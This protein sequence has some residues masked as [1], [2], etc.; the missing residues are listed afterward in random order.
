VKPYQVDYAIRTNSDGRLLKQGTVDLRARN[1]SAAKAAARE[2]VWE[3]DQQCS[4]RSG[5][6]VVITDVRVAS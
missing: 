6:S 2:W 3:N 5:P 1:V 4:P